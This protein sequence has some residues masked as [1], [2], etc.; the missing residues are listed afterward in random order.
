MADQ[1]TMRI[2]TLLGSLPPVGP[3]PMWVTTDKLVTFWPSA[4]LVTAYVSN[5]CC[6][7]WLATGAPIQSA[8]IALFFPYL[9]ISGFIA[10]C[11]LNGVFVKLDAENV[12]TAT[13]VKS[14]VLLAVIL[15][16]VANYIVWQSYLFWER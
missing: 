8:W 11:L 5:F 15:W 12:L 14:R 7:L 4:G 10:F 2:L 6:Y 9:V 1:K 13:A 3:A 16:P